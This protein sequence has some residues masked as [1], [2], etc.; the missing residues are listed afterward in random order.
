MEGYDGADQGSQ[1]YHE[2]LVVGLHGKGGG[3]LFQLEIG[4]KVEDVLEVVEDGVVDGQLLGCHLGQ[5]VPDAFQVS[6]QTLQRLQLRRDVLRQGTHGLILD[7]SAT[8]RWQR[9]GGGK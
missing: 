7:I 8:S 6:G 4:E 2:H 1:V 9:G 3:E 5:V